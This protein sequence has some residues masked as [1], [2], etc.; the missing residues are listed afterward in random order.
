MVGFDEANER[1]H[2]EAEEVEAEAEARVDVE[3]K[4]TR[5]RIARTAMARNSLRATY[6]YY[7]IL[8]SEYK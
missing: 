7:Y 3:G 4:R 6:A 5:A 2:E 1:R 8:G